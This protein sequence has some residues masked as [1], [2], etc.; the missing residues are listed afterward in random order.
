[1]LNVNMFVFFSHLPAMQF[2]SFR[3]TFYKIDK[4]SVAALS[5]VIAL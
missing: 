4:V 2:V 1:M 5:F 3:A